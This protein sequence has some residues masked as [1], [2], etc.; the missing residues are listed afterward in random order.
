M[1]RKET[2]S[3]VHR[4][5]NEIY[6]KRLLLVMAKASICTAWYVGMNSNKNK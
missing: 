2:D 6:G 3:Q 5:Q 4:E 1:G